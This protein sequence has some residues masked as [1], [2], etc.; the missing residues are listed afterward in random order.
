[1]SLEWKHRT[2]MV[3]LFSLVFC[4][5]GDTRSHLSIMLLKIV[6]EYMDSKI[7]LLGGFYVHQNKLLPAW[8]QLTFVPQPW[9]LRLPGSQWTTALTTY[10]IF[11]AGWD[12]CLFCF[13]YKTLF[14]FSGFA[15]SSVWWQTFVWQWWHRRN[16]YELQAPSYCCE[17]LLT[18]FQNCSNIKRATETTVLLPVT[19]VCAISM[20]DQLHVFLLGAAI[21]MGS[22]LFNACQRF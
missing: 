9:I 13:A 5:F 17:K 16:D 1:M 6:V 8:I 2:C 21:T 7:S 12:I 18:S 4:W 11:K 3:S 10:L 15:L 19:S 14:R 22:H 20:V